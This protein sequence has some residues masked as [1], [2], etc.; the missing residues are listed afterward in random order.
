MFAGMACKIYRSLETGV[1]LSIFGTHAKVLTETNTEMIT[2][3][4]ELFA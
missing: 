4:L 3:L 2:I 1:Q